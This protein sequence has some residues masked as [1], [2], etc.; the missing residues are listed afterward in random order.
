MNAAIQSGSSGR[1]ASLHLH[2]PTPGAPLQTVEVVEA[3]AGKGIQGEPRYFGRISGTTGKPSLRHVSL[4]EREQVAQH[5]SALGLESISPGAVRS[6]IE[7]T[8]IDLVALV[9]KEI[10]IGDSVLLVYEARKPCEKMNAVC[11]GLRDLMENDRQGVLA[12]V[13]RSGII[14]VGD[15]VK[16]CRSRNLDS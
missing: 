7:T 4:I 12:Q 10:Q 2:P 1:V 6:N 11:A 3:V 5:A 13:I 16:E 15:Q 9:G 8:G 14:R